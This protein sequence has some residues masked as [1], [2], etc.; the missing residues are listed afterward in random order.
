MIRKQLARVD[1][2]L[3]YGV[4]FVFF[5]LHW[6]CTV[7]IVKLAIAQE[8]YVTAEAGMLARTLPY[9]ENVRRH[10]NNIAISILKMKA[11]EGKKYDH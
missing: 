3:V 1:R 8:A 5:G 2:F 11:E 10:V 9:Y 7:I 4:A 6:L